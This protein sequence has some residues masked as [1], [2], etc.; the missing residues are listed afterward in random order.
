MLSKKERRLLKAAKKIEKATKK[1][2]SELTKV[3]KI[4][5]KTN[6]QLVSCYD[7]EDRYFKHMTNIARTSIN[8]ELL[9]SKLKGE[10]LPTDDLGDIL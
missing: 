9:Y 7:L 4:M 10:L 1:Y 3:D 5:Q 8:L 2:L 6:R